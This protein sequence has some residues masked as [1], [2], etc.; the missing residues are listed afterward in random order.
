M[1]EILWESGNK[2]VDDLK[3]ATKKEKKLYAEF[4]KKKV[5]Q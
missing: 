3:G 2:T 5:G 1:F 4:L